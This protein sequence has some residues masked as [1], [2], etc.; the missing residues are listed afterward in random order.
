LK[1]ENNITAQTKQ[2]EDKSNSGRVFSN[3]PFYKDED[4]GI[5]NSDCL[6]MQIAFRPADA[7]VTDLPYTFAGGVSNGVTS[8]ADS[9]YFYHWLKDVFGFFIKASTEESVWFL[10]GDWRTIALYDRCLGEIQSHQNFSNKKV[11]QVLIHNREMLGMGR[12]F[13]NQIEYIAFIKSQKSNLERIPKDVGNLINSYWY[14]GKHKHHPAEKDPKIMKQLIEWATDKGQT[15]L[16]PFMGSGTTLLAAKEAG[17][18]AMGIEIETKYCE[19]AVN[20]IKELHPQLNF[21][22]GT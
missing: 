8:L 16:D 2:P 10:Y 20:R 18:K 9:Q 4:I 7:I 17:R 5:H 14:Y 13:R 1:E 19:T 22:Q 21:R 11:S 15:V 3:V 12:P 6:E